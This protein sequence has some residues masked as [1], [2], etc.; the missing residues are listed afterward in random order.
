MQRIE[1]QKLVPVAV[2]EKKEHAEPLAQALLDA[3][4]DIIEVTFRTEAAPEVIRRIRHAFPDMLVGAGTLLTPMQVDQ[5]VDAGAAFGV[6]PG[7]NENVMDMAEELEFPFIPGVMTPSEMECGI[8][9]GCSLLKFFPASIA[10]GVKM[11]KA[12]G[13]TYAHTGVKFIPLGGVNAENAN[14][15]LALDHVAAVGGSWVV[16]KT[17]IQNEKWD[18]ITAT[19][20]AALDIIH[21]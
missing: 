21:G 20:K 8:E 15:Y 5:A 13:A 12:V 11:L 4:M 2:V 16:N 18:Q 14:E 9:R 6:A 17:M 3:G 10:G 7:L 19:T 1:K